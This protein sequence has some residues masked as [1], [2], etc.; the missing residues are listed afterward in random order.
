MRF[1]FTLNGIFSDRISDSLS[2]ERK[3]HEVSECDMYLITAGGM[4]NVMPMIQY[5]ERI[6]GS[7]Q[8][9]TTGPLLSGW[10]LVTSQARIQG[11]D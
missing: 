11:E 5:L 6:A 7:H 3:L 8:V 4:T 10:S 2:T 1:Y 9:I